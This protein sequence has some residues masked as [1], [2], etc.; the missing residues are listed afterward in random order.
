MR[1]VFISIIAALLTLGAI[2]YFLDCTSE[3]FLKFYQ[4][5]LRD[6][7]FQ[8]Y[9]TLGGFLYSLKTFIVVQMKEKVYD[10]KRYIERLETFRKTKPELSHYGPL[11]RLNDLLFFSVTGFI[12]V[13]LLNFTLGFINS[14]FTAFICSCLSVA[15]L[16]IFLYSLIIIRRNLNDWFHFLETKD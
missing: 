11:K 1:V 2:I 8:S 14:A 3:N 12:Y 16:F 7:L 10:H 13:A 9:L 5:K 15:V 6:N 4:D